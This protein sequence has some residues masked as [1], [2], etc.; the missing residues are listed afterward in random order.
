MQTFLVWVEIKEHIELYFYRQ[1]NIPGDM[2]IFPQLITPTAV[3]HRDQ[4]NTYREQITPDQCFFPLLDLD[5]MSSLFW[6][7]LPIL[8]VIIF[9]RLCRRGGG[10]RRKTFHSFLKEWVFCNRLQGSGGI[11]SFGW[12]WG[13]TD[14]KCQI[15]T[16]NSEMLKDGGGTPKGDLTQRRS[17]SHTNTHTHHV[18]VRTRTLYVHKHLHL[19]TLT[20]THTLWNSSQGSNRD[21]QRTVSI[22]TSAQNSLSRPD[23][24]VISITLTSLLQH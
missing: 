23:A 2:L 21:R 13:E 4:Q 14:S 7:N 3:M 16:S 6:Q 8:G 17:Q 18:C 15:L 1:G 22:Q 19:S 24:T 20:C 11:W 5:V 9:N 10:G 12:K